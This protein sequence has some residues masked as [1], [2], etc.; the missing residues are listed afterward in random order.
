MPIL[1]RALALAV[2]A[3]TMLVPASLLRLP[4]AYDPFAPLDL[5][6]PPNVLTGYKLERL[7]R[8]PDQCLRALAGSGLRHVRLPDRPSNVGCAIRNAV[9]VDG[10]AVRMAP[11]GFA[12][13]C[14]LAAAWVLFE[15]EVLQPAARAAFGQPVVEVRHLGSY[16]CRNLYGREGAARS[17]HATANAVDLAG[18]V[19]ADGREI[20]VRRD[21]PKLGTPE[22]AFLRAVHAGACRFFDVV[23][24]PGYNA[25]HHDHFHLDQGRWRA[26]R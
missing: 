21:W 6:A 10:A 14:G 5:T 8:E 11:T 15:H 23:L 2:F 20:S 18:F 19:L 3:A 22:S 26:C 13:T 24:G 9:R 4:S 25:A 17:E 16:A 7:Q 1:R 12:A